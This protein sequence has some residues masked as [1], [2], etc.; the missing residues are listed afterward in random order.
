MLMLFYFCSRITF[1]YRRLWAKNCIIDKGRRSVSLML[2]KVNI[3][4]FWLRLQIDSRLSVFVFELYHLDYS[5]VILFFLTWRNCRN[6]EIASSKQKIAYRII[7][8]WRQIFSIC[9]SLERKEIIGNQ[10]FFFYIPWFFLMCFHL[11][12]MVVFY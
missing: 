3:S 1:I 5:R 10:L 8:K 6:T 4:I 12:V 7:R 11:T 2:M 9:E